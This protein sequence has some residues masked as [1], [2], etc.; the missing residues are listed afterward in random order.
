MALSQELEQIAEAALAFA[1]PEERLAAVIP[2]EPAAG[3]RVY[4]CAFE[5]AEARSWIALDGRGFPLRDRR[6]VR[7]AAFIAA[8]CELAEERAAGGDLAG[9]RARLAELRERERMEGLEEAERAAAALER[10]ILPPPRVAS[11]A[12]LDRLGGAT[13]ELERALGEIGRSPFAEAMA[14]GAAAV[15]AVAAE[16]EAGYKLEL[17]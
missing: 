10:A 17:G 3:L 14:R 6:L 2:S 4:L 5:G 15:E 16:V 1:G 8:M 11:P 9:L 7:E 13:R 12:Y